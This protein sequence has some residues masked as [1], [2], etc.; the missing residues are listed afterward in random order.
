[1]AHIVEQKILYQDL[2][3]ENVRLT[4]L[5]INDVDDLKINLIDFNLFDKVKKIG[6]GNVSANQT[7]TTLFIPIKIFENSSIP[8]HHEQHK[9]EIAFWVGAFAIFHCYFWNNKVQR[10]WLNKPI[11]FALMKSNFLM[12]F[13]LCHKSPWLDQP[14]KKFRVYLDLFWA[15]CDKAIKVQFGNYVPDFQYP[16]MEEHN[17]DKRRQKTDYMRINP[18]ICRILNNAI[19]ILCDNNVDLTGRF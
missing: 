10:L 11:N 1:M 8:S 19:K 16:N 17:N 5:R 15:I 6:Q 14:V 13:I 3:F 4:R 9:D 18:W 12:A 7:R 2:S